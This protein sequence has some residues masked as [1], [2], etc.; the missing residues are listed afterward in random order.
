MPSSQAIKGD[1][2]Q[3]LSIDTV[4]I[5]LSPER[6]LQKTEIHDLLVLYHNKI[7]EKGVE[8]QDFDL[9]LPVKIEKKLAFNSAA[10][11]GK[12][13]NDVI[14][15]SQKID[16]VLSD[17]A[18]SEVYVTA[19]SGSYQKIAI[20]SDFMP[21]LLDGT[22][23]KTNGDKILLKLEK[24]ITNQ[25]KDDPDFQSKKYTQETVTFFVQALI[26]YCLEL[27]KVLER[28]EG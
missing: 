24:E 15:T 2:N 18:K 27:C 12:I 17:I 28:P 6:T 21:P 7:L 26:Y 9:S 16:E 10:R 11:Y 3:Q 14:N 4:N 19:V 25:I 20:E 23:S 8:N 22:A 5:R 1:H 13:F